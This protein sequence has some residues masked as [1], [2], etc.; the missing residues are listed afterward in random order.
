MGTAQST[1]ATS[2]ITGRPPKDITK[3]S[4]LSGRKQSLKEVLQPAAPVISSDE[5]VEASS[6]SEVSDDDYEE[7]SDD[8][9][10]EEWNERLAILEDTR[11]LRKVA[12]F[13]LCPEKPVI[14]SDPFACGRN[15]FNRASAPT[16]EEDAEREQ[17]LADAKALKKLAVDY[18]HPELPVATS[19]P[20]ACGRNY[21][22][23]PSADEYE[24]ED[25]MDDRDEILEDM[26]EMKKYAEYYLHPERPVKADAKL[27]GRNY[28]TRPSAPTNEEEAEREQILADAKALKKL[29]V[30]YMHPERPVVTS[31]PFACGRNY[32]T[33]SSAPTNEEEA[34]REQILADAKALKKLAVDYMHPEK[35]V[36]T[37]DPFAC[38]RN[39]FSRPSAEE[40]EDEDD[41]DERDEILEDMA[42]MKKYAEYYMYPERPVKADA[43][44]FGRNYFTRP[45]APTDE[46]E[47]EREQILADVKALKQLAVDY[48]HPERPVVTSDPFACARNY[49]TRPSA[50]TNEEELE[51]EQILADA[52]ALKKLA[53]DYMHPEKPVVTSDPFACGRNYFSRPSAE[54]YEDEDDMDERDEILEDM[55]EMKKYAEYYMYPERPVKADAKLFGR[56]YF[57]RPSAPTNEEEAEREQILA[58]AKAL[59][60]LAVDYM[61]PERPVVT[62]DPFACARNYFT[63]PS[64]PTNEEELEREQILAD[65]KALKKLAVDYMH[66][67][68]PVVT[69]DPFACARN[70]FTR[71]SAPTN[72][73]ELEREQILADAKAL[74]KLAVD[75]MHP[76]RPV[77]TSDPFACG[78]NYFSRPSAEEYEDEDDMDERDEILED[79]AEMKKYAEYYM[80]PERPVKADAKLF[81]RN[82]FTRPSAPTNEEEA[83]REQ[84]LADAK[85]LKKLAV[86]YMHPERPVV[87]SDPFACARNYFTRPSAPTNE[88]ELEREQILAD[89]KAL[90]KL[91]VDYMHP[92]RPVVDADAYACGRNYF[93]RASA[94]GHREH[95]HSQ[96]HAHEEHEHMYQH[97]YHVDDHMHSDYHSQS[98][99]FEMDEDVAHVFRD[100]HEN[101]Q[102]MVPLKGADVPKEAD[103][104]GNLSRSPS[105][106]MLFE[107]M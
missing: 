44:L 19:D 53:V 38:G 41:M 86:D 58:D 32:F 104:E 81:G 90:K 45:S 61:H 93:N 20:F 50:P 83:E 77:V 97:E 42:E 73:E 89:A 59:K 40:Y 76:E 57:T 74:K 66:P 70:Y 72:E 34:E 13:F 96:S 94:P 23:R 71:P 88:E 63:R 5:A 87:T 11:Q 95:I 82:Y 8:D 51:R 85:A 80:Y 54:E 69:S 60:K 24:D 47:A 31:D 22:T 7:D 9:E 25:D 46:E 12:E 10:D 39:Y 56:N 78:R 2:E 99:H 64:A 92:E 91:A 33:R 68:R 84:I 102:A 48:M 75:Y 79:M 21:F 28:F 55:A 14:T 17:I 98:D 1:Q 106:V 62:S 30:D 3:T 65:A 36:V 4:S 27:F 16:N 67:E 52:K 107:G 101:L 18:L 105:S 100:F 29:A 103:E 37:S 26:A 43:K 6:D 49:F 15:Y 35:P